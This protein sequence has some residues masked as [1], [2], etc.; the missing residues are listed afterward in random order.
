MKNKTIDEKIDEKVVFHCIANCELSA[1]TTM[2]PPERVVVSTGEIAKMCLW[3]KYRTK[4]QS[5]GLLKKV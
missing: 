2:Y 3:S 1:Y 5:M 4:R